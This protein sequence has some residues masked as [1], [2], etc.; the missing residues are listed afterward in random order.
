MERSSLLV[1]VLLGPSQ[2]GFCRGCPWKGNISRLIFHR[3][4]HKV[5][6]RWDGAGGSASVSLGIVSL[7]GEEPHEQ[8]RQKVFMCLAWLPGGALERDKHLPSILMIF[9]LAKG[10]LINKW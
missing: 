7:K 5:Q 10:C 2:A 9:L 6:E 3:G 4:K 1:S 8:I